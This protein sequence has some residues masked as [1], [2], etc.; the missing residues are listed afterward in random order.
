MNEKDL[1][2]LGLFFKYTF[3]QG[4]NYEDF[5]PFE[6]CDNCKYYD[7]CQ[8]DWLSMV[9]ALRESTGITV[10]FVRRVP[11]GIWGMRY[12]LRRFLRKLRGI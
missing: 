3:D 6:A 1:Y 7:E 11:P 12:S 2:C 9:N 5:E 10:S 4:K 8:G